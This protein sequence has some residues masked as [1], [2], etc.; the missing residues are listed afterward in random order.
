MF[1][2]GLIPVS[3]APASLKPGYVPPAIHQPIENIVVPALGSTINVQVRNPLDFPVGMA[4]FIANGSDSALLKV[5]GV[6]SETCSLDL[7]N[8]GSSYTSPAGTVIN[9][10]VNLVLFGPP[11]TAYQLNCEAQIDIVLC[12]DASGSFTSPAEDWESSKLFM[13]SIMEVMSAGDLNSNIQFGIVEMGHYNQTVV[14]KNL[15]SDIEDLVDRNPTN[16]NLVLQYMEFP[17]GHTIQT[18]ACGP[19]TA[20]DY[21]KACF[22]AGG[23]DLV[24]GLNLAQGVLNASSRQTAEQIIIMITDGVEVDSNLLLSNAAARDVEVNCANNNPAHVAYWDAQTPIYEGSKDGEAFSGEL[25][26][27]GLSQGIEAKGDEI[28]TSGTRIMYVLADVGDTSWDGNGNGTI[29][30]GSFTRNDVIAHVK[31]AASFPS[32]DNVF[33]EIESPQDLITKLYDIVEA[34]C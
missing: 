8:Y 28:I 17:D 23:T 18:P 34:I 12:L 29:P 10:D 20:P 3:S 33:D 11:I 19:C 9:G 4:V 30:A 27:G 2:H 15:S 31:R 24:E 5:V 7:L 22:R 26:A 13:A 25:V 16:P 14:H 32:R 6:N 21:W 1:V